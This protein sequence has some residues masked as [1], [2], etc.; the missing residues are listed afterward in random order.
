MVFSATEQLKVMMAMM[1]RSGQE[2][3][4]LGQTEAYYY[5]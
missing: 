1:M 3:C 5:Y 4:Y 2:K